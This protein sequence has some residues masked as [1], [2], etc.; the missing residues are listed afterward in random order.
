M[1]NWREQFGDETETKALADWLMT[2]YHYPVLVIFIG[3]AFWNRFRNYSNF[4]VDGEI[5]YSG[6]DPWYHM[7]STEYVINNFPATMPYDPWTQFP[8]GTFTG[9][10]GTIFDQ[11]IALVAL[12]V[13]LG[14]P[15]EYTGRL[16]I[17]IA[18]ALFGVLVCLPVYFVGHRLGGRLGG[19]LGV[20]FVAFAPDRLLEVSLAGNVQ[21]HSAEVLFL[22]LSLLGF[23]IAI[24]A[25][26]RELPVYELVVAREFGIIRKTIGYS[27]LAGV[28]LGVYLWAWPPG[29]WMFGIIGAFFV[30]HMMAEHLRGRSPEHTAFV[31]VIAF[32]TAALMQLSTVGTLEL[33]ATDR[34]LVQP[35]LGLL[36]AVGIAFLAWLSRTVDSQNMTPLVYP[37]GV[38]GIIV[39]GIAGM[40]LLLPSVFGFFANEFTRVFGASIGWLDSL[41]WFTDFAP[42]RGAAATIG[43]GRAAELSD[44]RN[45]YQFAAFTAFLGALLLLVRQVIDSRPRGEELFIVVVSAFLVVATFTQIRFGYY[46]ILII[47]ALNAALVGFIMQ[48]A[49][50]PDSRKL[51]ETYQVLTVG[52]IVMV[53]FVPLLGL[54][55][56]G[57]GQTAFGLADDRS[58][59]GDVMGWDDSLDWMSEETPQPGQYANPDGEPM[60]YYGQYERTDN[61]DYPP[62]AYGVLSWWDYGHWITAKGERIPNANPFQHGADEAA[63]F[64]LAQSEE[65]AMEVLETEFDQDEDAQ[66]RYVMIDSL[67]VES[68][69]FAGGKF[70]APTDFHDEFERGDFYR[71]AVDDF[72]NIEATIQKQNY[73]ESMMVRLYHHHGSSQQAQPFVSQWAGQEQRTDDGDAFVDAVEGNQTTVHFLN[74]MTEAEEW[75][76]V[77]QTSQIGGIGPHPEQDVE[78]LEQF[79]LV[80][81]DA[82]PAVPN[83]GGNDDLWEQNAER[84]LGT[85]PAAV[86]IQRNADLLEQSG[87]NESQIRPEGFAEQMDFLFDGTPAF[88]KTFERVPGATIQGTTHENVTANVSAG[89]QVDISVPIDQP[90]GESFTYTQQA[91]LDENLEFEATVPYSTVG[92]DDWGVEEGYTN[93]S[94]RA[95]DGYDIRVGGQELDQNEGVLRFT[96]ATANVTEGQV[97]G[98]DDAPVTV[99]LDEQTQEFDLD[100]GDG[101][102]GG[103]EPG[104][105]ENGDGETGDGENGDGE[106]GDGE[107]GDGETGD[108]ENGDGET[109][110][111]E[112]GDGETGDGETGDGET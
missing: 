19:V 44:I 7:R 22:G 33:S 31:G 30:L 75:V 35:G 13:G 106:T 50:S 88:T 28:A 49:G 93:V 10:F 39:A 16:V 76:E 36:G 81:A 51:P 54:P 5:F 43:E 96:G 101:D 68:D 4:I 27:M 45:F 56:V 84:G 90:N 107:N 3:F 109:G 41:I 61:F 112:N 77:N 47:A 65:E 86:A 85:G 55:V 97:I 1:S 20:M 24:R 103:G 102:I 52:V 72:G 59:P 26:E 6:N 2:Y 79:R 78:A 38:L 92:Y 94:A 58:Q 74:N 80:H 98:E 9:Q 40:A 62:G 12:I 8:F 95:I 73:Y 37:V 23:M 25:A 83:T 108:G 48:L 14:N 82:V 64:F 46:L 32:T 66:T 18:P 11:L 42:E 34:S 70:F 69:S 99:E 105:G 111:G 110:D 100:F 57:G 15:G 91:E 21:H 53:M 63:E 89:D 60:E 71:T 67:M 87:G 29:V 104:D 17:L